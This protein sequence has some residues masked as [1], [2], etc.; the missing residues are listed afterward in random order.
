MLIPWSIKNFLVSPMV[1]SPK[2][3]IDAAKTAS[4]LPLI[5]ASDKCSN[6]PAPPDAIIGTETA[7]D[8]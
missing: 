6:F 4:A 1:N 8:T 2:W 5:N 3:N 7:E